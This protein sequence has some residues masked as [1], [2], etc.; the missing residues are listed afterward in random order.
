MRMRRIIALRAM[1]ASGLSQ[2]E[3][4]SSLN[5]SQPAISQQ[6]KAVPDT[7]TVPARTLLEAAGPV[8]RQLAHERGFTNLA[9]FGSVARDEARL[10]S[11]IDL[12]VRQPEGTTI[13]GLRRLRELF[14]T[15]LGRSVD[16]VTYGG[17]KPGIDDD[18]LR[19]AVAV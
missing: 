14:E 18:I 5:V 15:I 19:E 6:L 1:V 4:A 10:G 9:V 7:S 17:L 8:L 2:R 11:D 16:L 3:I 13:A 12:L